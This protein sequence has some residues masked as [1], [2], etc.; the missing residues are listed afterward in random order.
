MCVISWCISRLKTRGTSK[1]IICIHH[2]IL[3]MF[4]VVSSVCKRQ[5]E[6]RE[7]WGISSLHWVT[8]SYS[9]TFTCS[10]N[11]LF[12]C[13]T[14]FFAQFEP[15]P[16]VWC[17]FVSVSFS[18]EALAWLVSGFFLC[19]SCQIK[20]DDTFLGG[21]SISSQQLLKFGHRR[22]TRSPFQR[23]QEFHTVYWG[24]SSLGS[25]YI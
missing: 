16:S 17:F 5:T 15:S 8:H 25:S 3:F 24:L 7:T 13:S 2:N 20:K 10:I 12:M 22:G 11:T 6:R 4:L 18:L 23:L 9:L 1:E 21:A 14:Q 19:M